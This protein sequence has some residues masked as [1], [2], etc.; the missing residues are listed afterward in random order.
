LDEQRNMQLMRHLDLSGGQ[1]F[2]TTTDKRW[3]HLEGDMQL[4]RVK[5]GELRAV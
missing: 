4:F 1:V 3:I 2:I 5:G